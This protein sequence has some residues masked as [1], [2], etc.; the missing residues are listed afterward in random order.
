MC[1][2]LEEAYSSLLISGFTCFLNGL[3]VSSIVYDVGE[4]IREKR[5][6]SGI[7]DWEGATSEDRSVVWQ[8]L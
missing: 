8:F 4:D 2:L 1:T 5:L 3:M 6:A 7:L